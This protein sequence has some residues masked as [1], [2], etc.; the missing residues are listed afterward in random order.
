MRGEGVGGGGKWKAGDGE[1]REKA[2]GEWH[3]DIRAE[4]AR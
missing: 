2:G 1:G 4:E 3:G